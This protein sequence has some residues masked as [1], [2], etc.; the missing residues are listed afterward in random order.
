MIKDLLPVPLRGV[1]PGKINTRRS[2]VQLLMH[3]V[4]PVRNEIL[5]RIPV[6]FDDVCNIVYVGSDTAKVSDWT[7]THMLL[8]RT[9]RPYNSE[10]EELLY[11]V[12]MRMTGFLGPF[13]LGPLGN[14]TG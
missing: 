5:V 3:N 12:V 6:V 8:F 10:Q 4:S 9:M 11:P 14:W 13:Q 2:L 7:R 1:V